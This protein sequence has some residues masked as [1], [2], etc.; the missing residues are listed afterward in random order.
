MGFIQRLLS[1]GVEDVRTFGGLVDKSTGLYSYARKAWDAVHASINRGKFHVAYDLPESLGAAAAAHASSAR[2][3]ANIVLAPPGAAGTAARGTMGM[4]TGSVIGGI[5]GGISGYKLNPNQKNTDQ[6]M[7]NTIRGIVMG[8]VGGGVVGGL[9][10]SAWNKSTAAGLKRLDDLV[11]QGVMGALGKNM[12]EAEA[13]AMSAVDI[14]EAAAEASVRVAGSAADFA[15]G[16]VAKSPKKVAAMAAVGAGLYY[17]RGAILNMNRQK[18]PT[19]SGKLKPLEG[20]DLATKT[21]QEMRA[22]ELMNQQFL[23]PQGNVSSGRAATLARSTGG[24]VQGLHNG[25]HG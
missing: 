25:R 11:E 4:M 12:G 15:L 8:T 20:V 14:G 1:L 17:G 16:V 22:A 5:G 2:K 13:H 10:A 23:L 9:A 18:S 24:L 7:K 6:R 19:K 21:S 3:I